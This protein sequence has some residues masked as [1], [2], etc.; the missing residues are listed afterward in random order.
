MWISKYSIAGSFRSRK[1]QL[2]QIALSKNGLEAGFNTFLFERG[3]KNIKNK[4]NEALPNSHFG[5]SES[6]QHI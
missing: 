1:I 3:Q 2:W 4:Q 5:M 6:I